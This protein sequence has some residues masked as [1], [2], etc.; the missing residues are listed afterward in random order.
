MICLFSIDKDSAGPFRAGLTGETCV[1]KNFCRLSCVPQ[2]I[3]LSLARSLA[4]SRS[5]HWHCALPSATAQDFEASE[6]PAIDLHRAFV[7]EVLFLK[8]T[9][10]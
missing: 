9:V 10:F 5:N 8:V 3:S 1:A 2:W 4:L 7:I 6:G